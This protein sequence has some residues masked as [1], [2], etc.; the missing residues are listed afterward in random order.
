MGG[1]NIIHAVVALEQN[2]QE[3]YKTAG[4]Q[5][6]NICEEY[7]VQ[8]ESLIRKDGGN[9]LQLQNGNQTSEGKYDKNI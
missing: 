4:E 1:G 6:W 2:G 7:T 9:S 8:L 5:E 3:E